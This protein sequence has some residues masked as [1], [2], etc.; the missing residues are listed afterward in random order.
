MEFAMMQRFGVSCGDGTLA[1]AFLKTEVLPA[2]ETDN[3]IVFNF[4]GVR[5]IN[6]S[7]SNALFGNLVKTFGIGVF[8]KLKI[9]NASSAVRLEIQSSATMGVN[10]KISA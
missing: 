7:F 4:Q 3:H 2:I 1:L 9:V 5:I 10:H 6:S 8:S